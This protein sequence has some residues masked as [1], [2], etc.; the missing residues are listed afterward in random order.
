MYIYVY[1]HIY[2]YS[3]YELTQGL[4]LDLNHL[5]HLKRSTGHTHTHRQRT[6]PPTPTHTHTTRTT[7]QTPKRTPPANT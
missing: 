1:T 6:T 7:P 2:T 4:T 3:L 5:R